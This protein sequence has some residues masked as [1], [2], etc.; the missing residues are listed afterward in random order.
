MYSSVI[1]TAA[2][3]ADSGVTALN[4]GVLSPVPVYCFA[5]LTKDGSTFGKDDS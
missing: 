5:F 1:L 3:I 2:L 4:F